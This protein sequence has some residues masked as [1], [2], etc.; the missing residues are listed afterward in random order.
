MEVFM[1]EFSIYG[2]SFSDCLRNLE[3][4]LEWCVKSNLVLNWGK[5][6]FM[7]KEGIVL[8][9]FVF[10]RGIKVDQEKFEVI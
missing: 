7:I 9:H 5:C 1:D 6:H 4:V 10:S 3:K 8:R 2:S